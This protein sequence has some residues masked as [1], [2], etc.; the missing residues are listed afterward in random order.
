MYNLRM[1]NCIFC[2]IV[3]GSIPSFKVLEDDD[4]FAF[5]SIGPHTPGHSLVIPKKH[6]DYFFDLDDVTLQKILLFSKKIEKAQ[7]KAFN[8][9]TGKVGVAIAG[10]EVPHAHLHLIPLNEMG[11]LD[12]DH[13]KEVTKEELQNNLDKL[14][15]ALNNE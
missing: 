11:D 8:P 7:R 15:G 5:L 1:D 14:K 9:K 10:L 2:K 6:T 3:D 4:F 13:A 12:F